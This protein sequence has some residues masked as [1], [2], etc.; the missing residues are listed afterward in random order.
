MKLRS[1]VAGFALA[2]TVLIGGAGA[3]FAAGGS[4]S[5]GSPKGGAKLSVTDRCDRISARLSKQAAKTQLIQERIATLQSRLT[6]HPARA[7]Q[8]NA[9]I[10]E[11]EQR[12]T[13]L[14]NVPAFYAQHCSTPA[15]PPTAPTTTNA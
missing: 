6:R 15:S 8:I 10:T 7:V 3:A 2:G 12:L 14:K 5:S 4:G 13:K 11:L 9:R 1:T